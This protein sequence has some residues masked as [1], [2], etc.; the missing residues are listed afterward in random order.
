MD[1]NTIQQ[2]IRILLQF[3]AG[4]L[5]SRGLL[6]ADMAAQAVGALLSLGGIAWWA[7]WNRKAI[8]AK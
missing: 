8:D 4:L 3:G 2:F 5:V 6:T 1:W 7:V